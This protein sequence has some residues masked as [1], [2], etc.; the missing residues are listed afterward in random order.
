MNY[1]RL[2]LRPALVCT[3]CLTP[4]LA[5]AGGG[6]STTGAGGGTVGSDGMEVGVTGDPTDPGGTSIGVTDSG[7]D[8]G[9]PGTSGGTD[10]GT[11]GG[12]TDDGG[13]SSG[14]VCGRCEVSEDPV[15]I[16]SPEDG[17]TVGTLF[18]VRVTA[19]HTCFCDDCGCFAADPFSVTLRVD[20]MTFDSCNGD[21]CVT[22]D[23]TFTVMLD[24][25][26]YT[27]DAAADH[28]GSPSF[29]DPITVTVEGEVGPSD[30]SGEPPPPPPPPLPSDSSGSSGSS[31]TTA[32]STDTGSGGCGCTTAPAPAGGAATLLALFGLLG[33]RRRRG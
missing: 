2:W 28:E 23:H 10:E 8:T 21:G 17:T 12:S 5:L 4:A 15:V 29:S 3:L 14:E 1:A 9:F 11:S 32:G 30:S 24:P 7:F 27:L 33:L 16:V 31:G 25:G 13:S 22:S 20:G 6:T 26:E 19:P 18:E